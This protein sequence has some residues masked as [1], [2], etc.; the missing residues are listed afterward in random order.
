[1]RTSRRFLTAAMLASAAL[2]AGPVVL[3]QGVKLVTVDVKAVGEGWR[4]SELTGH[5]VVNDDN[6]DIGEL[7][8]FIVGRD[9][10]ALFSVIEVGGFLGMGGHLVAVPF[11]SL[12]VEDAGGDLKIVLPGATKD[13][14]EDLPEF[15]YAS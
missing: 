2:I 5:A 7:D 14:L 11:D 13:A 1:M 4:T 12:E 3:A 10:N 15:N 6:E 9:D 8:D